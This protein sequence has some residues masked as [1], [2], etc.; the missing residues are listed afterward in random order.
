MLSRKL[1]HPG[2]VKLFPTLESN[3]LGKPVEVG[4]AGIGKSSRAVTVADEEE[5]GDED[6]DDASRVPEATRVGRWVLTAVPVL[7]VV[8]D[9]SSSSSSCRRAILTGCS[10]WFGRVSVAPLP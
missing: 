9:E 6:E 5:E 2:L 4:T 7:V 10:G 8:V 1:R 3:G